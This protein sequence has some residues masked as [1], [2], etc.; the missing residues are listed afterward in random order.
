[1]LS[2]FW[3]LLFFARATLLLIDI[4]KVQTLLET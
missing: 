2:T 1:M 3:V 4:Q